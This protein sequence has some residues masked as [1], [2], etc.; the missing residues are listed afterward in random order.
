V[1]ELLLEES[2]VQPIQ[3]PVT[4]CGDIHGTT[5]VLEPERSSLSVAGSFADPH[6]FLPVNPGQFYDL[7]ELFRVGG[8]MPTTHY[9]FMVCYSPCLFTKS[10]CSSSA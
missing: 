9:I 10:F 3:G 6:V 4:I 2:N 7:L 8:E 5:T 1:K